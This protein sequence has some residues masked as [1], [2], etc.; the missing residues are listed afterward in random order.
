MHPWEGKE[1]NSMSEAK[2]KEKRI[3]SKEV[4]EKLEKVLESYLDR[5]QKKLEDKNVSTDA[6]HEDIRIMHHIVKMLQEIS[7]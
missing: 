6:V 5:V 3:M 2:E 7:K 4:N 1:G